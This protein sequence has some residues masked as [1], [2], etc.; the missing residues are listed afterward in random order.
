MSTDKHEREE[1]SRAEAEED[2]TGGVSFSDLNRGETAKRS[3]KKNRKKIQGRVF[4]RV[5]KIRCR[6]LLVGLA[7]S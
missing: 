5:E 2:L 7:N 1:K 3:A 6:K 4:K